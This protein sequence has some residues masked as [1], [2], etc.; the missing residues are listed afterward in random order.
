[1]LMTMK[2]IR[3]LV[4]LH[5]LLPLIG[6]AQLH[7]YWLMQELGQQHDV[8]ILAREDDP[9]RDEY[10]ERNLTLGRVRVKLVNIT[11]A[12]SWAYYKDA[13]VERLFI[14]V[15]KEFVP[16]VIFLAHTVGLSASIINV[17]TS[18]GIPTVVQLRDFFYMCHRL[19]LFK[20]DLS[21][22]SGPHGGSKCDSCMA[23]DFW[24]DTPDGT[25][26]VGVVRVK[27]MQEALDKASIVFGHSDFVVEKFAEFG[28]S[29][30][31]LRVVQGGIDV[32]YVQNVRFDRRDR[33]VRFGYFGGVLPY[34]GVETIVCAFVHLP[35]SSAELHINGVSSG[36]FESRLRSLSQGKKVQFYGP[37]SNERL[38]DVLSNID[39]FVHASTIHEHY[40]LTI[41]EA[42]AA[43]IPVIVSNLRAQ[44]DAVRDGIDG[45]HFKAGYVDDLQEKMEQVL[46]DRGLLNTF[47]KNILPVR[48]IDEEAREI[49]EML[50]DLVR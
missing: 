6:G 45:L 13:D 50:S 7:T 3:I 33:V 11:K 35:D 41:R 12:P 22:C 31:K 48:T 1:M 16:D 42:F 32:R 46:V 23:S 8:M 29:R 25:E 43:K 20:T 47:R 18:L 10:D 28:V 2:R 34:K 44:C 39:I 9:S 21:L 19:H 37:Y 30:S 14:R 49:E 27:Y 36:P 4:T 17:A 24:S 38:G 26:S 5:Y 40:P 15:V